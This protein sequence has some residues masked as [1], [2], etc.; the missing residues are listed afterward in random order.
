MCERVAGIEPAS[1]G[2]KPNILPLNY[3]RIVQAQINVPKYYIKIAKEEL[4]KLLGPLKFF[5][6]FVQTYFHSSPVTK[7][8]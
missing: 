3:T 1:L 7:L 2:W 4:E 8:M 5:S 6:D